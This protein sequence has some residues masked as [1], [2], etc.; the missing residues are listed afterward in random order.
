MS[1]QLTQQ[2]AD[3]ILHFLSLDE[4]AMGFR[5]SVKKMGCSG[6]GYE[7]ELAHEVKADEMTMEDKGVTLIVPQDALDKVDGT[8]IDYER[9]GINQIFVYRNPNATGS[10]GCGESFTTN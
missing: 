1:L 6:W 3:R 5:V 9:Q 7:V 8:V 10:C 2:A 4:K